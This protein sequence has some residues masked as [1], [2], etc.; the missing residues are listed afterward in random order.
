MLTRHQVQN[1]PGLSNGNHEEA[2]I[3]L[4]AHAAF[5]VKEHN[6][7]RIVIEANDTDIII[8]AIYHY[9]HLPGLLELWVHKHSSVGSSLPTV[10]HH[11]SIW[12]QLT[13]TVQI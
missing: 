4:F 2:D 12:K 11:H 1:V 10:P 13:Q 3:F 8:M 7:K 6:S 9:G 5:E